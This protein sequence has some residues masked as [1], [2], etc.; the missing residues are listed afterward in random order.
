[1]GRS[2]GRMAVLLLCC[3]MLC[4]IP[5]GCGQSPE[6]ES[7]KG[8][9]AMTTTGRSAETDMEAMVVRLHDGSL[10]LVDNRSGSP[11]VPTA[12]DE[13]DIIGLDGQT[14]T[15]DDLQVGNVVRVVGNG[16][17]MQSYPGQYPGIETIEVIKEG[18]S[19]DAEE[20]ADLIAELSISMDPSQPASANLEYVTDLASVTLMLQDNGYTW[21]YEENGEPTQVIADAAHP[22]QINPADLPDVR[23]DQPLDVTIVFDRT[24]TALT[25]TRWGEQ[26]IE[27]AASSAGGYQNI[28][29]DPL[30]GE[31]VDVALDGAKAVLTVEPGYRYVVDAEFAEGTVCYVFTVHE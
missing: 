15:V 28:D 8:A 13:A 27:Q 7:T 10:L 18:S 31:P 22:V 2:M 1:M 12:I 24:A 26:A 17:M 29:V 6:A 14:L 9:T 5:A 25:V 19:A 30:S 21:T 4:M 23:V 11:F 16:I 3:T 20:Y